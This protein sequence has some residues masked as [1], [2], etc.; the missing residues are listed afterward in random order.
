MNNEKLIATVPDKST[1]SLTQMR[2]N[3]RKEIDENQEILE[4]KSFIQVLDQELLHRVSPVHGGWKCGTQEEPRFFFRS[5]PK[6]GLVWRKVTHTHTNSDIYHAELFG[7][8]VRGEF[9]SVDEARMAVQQAFEM[10]C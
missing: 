2:T 4:T 6:I 10:R 5:G 8:P 1:K 3:A 7:E 9:Q